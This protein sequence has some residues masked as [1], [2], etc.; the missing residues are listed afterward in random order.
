LTSSQ[1]GPHRPIYQGLAA[2]SY[3]ANNINLKIQ[4]PTSTSDTL[5]LLATDWV[6]IGIVSLLDFLT[7]HWEGDAAY[8]S[9]RYKLPGTGRCAAWA[10]PLWSRVTSG[11]SGGG[12]LGGI[13]EPPDRYL[14]ALPHDLVPGAHVRRGRVRPAATSARSRWSLAVMGRTS[15]VWAGRQ[16]TPVGSGAALVVTATPPAPGRRAAGY[17]P[18]QRPAAHQRQRP[19]RSDCT[20]P[21]N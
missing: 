13:E 3:K 10:I 19:R 16:G 14:A 17:G 12:R 2:G 4:T 20:A 15:T 8:R 18:P 5:R 1:P 9:G 7:S 11:R 21:A 6:D